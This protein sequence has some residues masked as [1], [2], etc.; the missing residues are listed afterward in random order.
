[1]TQAAFDE[2]L[3]RGRVHRGEGR[4]ADAIPCFRRA[5][6]EDPRSPVPHFHLGEALWQL[7]LADDA[8]RAWTASANLDTSFAAPRLA[9]AEVALTRGDF[10]S[11]ATNATQAA[12]LQPD[13]ARARVT[14]IAARAA[15][16]EAPMAEAASSLAEHPG[17]A[18]SLPLILLAALAERGAAIP[19]GIAQRAFT[20]QDAEALRRLALVARATDRDLSDRLAQTYCTLMASQRAATVPLMWPLRTAG[21]K[22]RL[23]WIMPAPDASNFAAAHRGLDGVLQVL[24]ARVTVLLLCSGDAG[25]TRAAIGERTA[26]S[27]LTMALPSDDEPGVAKAIAVRDCD[28]LVDAA[29]LAARI[30][31]MLVLRPA[32]RIVALDT[33]TPPH[34]PPVVDAL[35]TET[36][37]LTI[38]LA[39]L[40]STFD[41]R[42]G[43]SV[44]AL[45][46]RW[47]AAVRLHAEGDLDASAAAYAR[48]LEAQPG[49]APALHL[50]GVVAAAR[51][52]KDEAARAFAAAIAAEPRFVDARVSAAE[53][54]LSEH[55]ADLAHALVEEGLALD[56]RNLV[57]LRLRGRVML[58]RRDGAGAERAFRE[59]LM[60]APADADAHFRH[61]VALQRMGDPAAAARAYQRAL[62]LRPDLIDA[63]FNL[64]V[65]FEQQGNR[66]AAEAAYSHVLAV[67]PKHVA[68]YKR[69]GELLFAGGEIDRW[70][71][72][73]HAFEKH[74]PK[75]LALAVQA[76]EACQHEGDFARLE[77]Y[78]DGLRRDDYRAEDEEDLA[79]CLES[80]LYLL[81][82][83]DVEPATMLRLSQAYDALAP[84]V[85]G[86]R[87]PVP[88]ARKPG[89]LRVGYLSGDL[90]NHVMG[91]MMWQAVQHHDRERFELFFYST[92]AQRDD[93]TAR[94]E[95]IAS[96][97]D[98]V[99]LLDDASAAARIAADDLDLLVDLSTHTKGSRP[100]I[101]AAKPARVALTH[102]ASAGTVGLSQIDWKLTDRYCDVPES[103][104]FMIERLLA[105]DG[106]VYPYRH[107]PPAPAHPFDRAQL[108]IP[109]GAVVIGAFVNPLKLSRRCL[110]LWREVLERIPE[111]LVAFSPANPA[112]RASYV[113]I[114]RAGGI[115]EEK[116]VFLPQGRT[117]EENQA[118][119]TVVD[120]VLDTMPF[121]GVNGTIEALDMNVPVVTLAGRRH[122]E[123][124]SY[125]ILENLGVRS[126]IA[127]SGRDYVAIAERLARDAGFRAAVKRDIASG[128]AS[129]A[130]V[131]MPR[132]TRNL[133]AAYV[134]AIERWTGG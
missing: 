97:F 78:I 32:R 105:M 24:Q 50:A 11:A 35:F 45:A 131:D 18:A 16:G 110:R 106:C 83:F 125:S 63:D 26:A 48:V 38:E 96:R 44:D 37:R 134:S 122:G 36:S 132:H 89:R 109:P 119:Y 14:A 115:G 116:L 130:L 98:F 108:R 102:V 54:A 52:R 20:M 113:R 85:Y 40:Q 29:G 17:I 15:L 60:L 12:E 39:Q 4:P 68:A 99:A 92:T 64:G 5:A 9:L 65:I 111:A 31:S 114:A 21:P 81:L 22:L 34:R 104:E 69:L 70:L 80:L 73:F 2:W 23:A 82:F 67:D 53:L 13:N 93:W 133:E 57:L 46:E 19:E 129:S 79:D 74:C 30:A 62:T 84:K 6:R 126:T 103:Q 127:Q 8:I 55:D 124:S 7:G 94:F 10:A 42:P 51:E 118:R 47:D 72:N 25:R 90:R 88:A 59:L 95:G 76:L 101:L 61:G 107:V 71:A 87:L 120:L 112:Q 100:G 77:H 66:R 27:M 49:H 3:A 128:I 121:G 56:P 91:K 86:P 58:R 33:G 75:S 123:R 117:D 43:E 1:M 41:D 28:V